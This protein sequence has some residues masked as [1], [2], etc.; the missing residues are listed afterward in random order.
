MR[1]SPYIQRRGWRS[2]GDATRERPPL[3]CGRGGAGG[4][5]TSSPS[6]RHSCRESSPP[7]PRSSFAGEPALSLSKR[8]D[9]RRARGCSDA[10]QATLAR[11]FCSPLNSPAEGFGRA[12]P[13]EGLRLFWDGLPDAATRLNGPT[14]YANEWET[15]KRMRTVCLTLPG[16]RANPVA[17]RARAR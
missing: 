10:V 17:A 6:R 3:P 15:N 2:Y 1:Y 13:L 8:G 11:M 5:R 16:R 12:Q 14:K 9:R 7:R 4:V